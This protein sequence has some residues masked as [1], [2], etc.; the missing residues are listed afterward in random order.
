M[1]SNASEGEVFGADVAGA[2][3]GELFEEAGR[4]G[5]SAAGRRLDAGG[6]LE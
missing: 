4:A 6:L 3:D 1:P 2:A 5:A